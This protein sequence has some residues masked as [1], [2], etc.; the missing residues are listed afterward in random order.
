MTETDML[1]QS[2]CAAPADATGRLALSDLL[3]AHEDMELADAVQGTTGPALLV[4]L[5]ALSVST[6][7]PVSHRL[8]WAA[9]TVLPRMAGVPQVPVPVPVGVPDPPEL[10]APWNNRRAVPG[11]PWRQGAPVTPWGQWP[12]FGDDVT[13]AVSTF[14][15]DN[16]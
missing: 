16:Q 2:C 13:W 1:V 5:R 10:P 12:G 4:Y 15:G 11:G 14:P 3:R 6:N 9:Y 8:L 7:L